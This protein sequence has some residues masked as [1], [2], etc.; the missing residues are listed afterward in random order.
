MRARAAVADDDGY[1]ASVSDLMVGL[2]FVFIIV[3]ASFGLNF[4]VAQ[5]EA[6]SVIDEL[7]VERDELKEAQA[8]L[9][10]RQTELEDIQVE[11]LERQAELLRQREALELE[12]DIL[13]AK[14]RQIT[15]IARLYTS[16]N[17]IRQ[18]ML[19]EIQNLLGS[20]D[21][22]V[23]IVPENGVLRLPEELLFESGS[24]QLRPESEPV[25]LLLAEV[26]A[27]VLPC[28]TLRAS[29]LGPDC[30]G[31]GAGLIETV[32]VEGHTDNVPL[33]G[34]GAFA[35]NWDLAARRGT[36]VFTRLTELQPSLGVL[37]NV[38]DEALLGVS[39]YEARRPVSA[40]DTDEARRKN[41]RIDIRFVILSPTDEQLRA[42]TDTFE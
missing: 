34:G 28:H 32:L 17:A 5:N 1:L 31:Q 14:D 19:E 16:R 9:L 40:E 20:R 7:A 26:M 27:R 12:R 13:R 33:S 36:S 18:A 30:D 25:L 11:L 4:K 21:V 8:A 22:L 6:D 3:L 23:S 35:D 2:L 10:A 38:K 42:I 41:R 39:A 37:K 15:D 24:A 29:D